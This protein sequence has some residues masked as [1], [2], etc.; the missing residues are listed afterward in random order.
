[1]GRR[2]VA[3]YGGRHPRVSVLPRTGLR[4]RFARVFAGSAGVD[5]YSAATSDVYQ[6]LFGAGTFTGKGLYDVDAF[7]ATAGRALPENR[8]LSHDLIESTFARC[9][10]VP[11]VE[12][13]DDFPAKYHAY[14]PPEP[15]RVRGHW[16]L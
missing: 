6:D 15:R 4:S 13:F 1:R 11:D 9:R 7:H 5:P 16:Q 10:L 2:G 3:R 8:V 14:A 12:V